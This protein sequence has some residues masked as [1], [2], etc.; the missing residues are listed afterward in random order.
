M[1]ESIFWGKTMATVRIT[2]LTIKTII[3]TNTWERTTKQKVVI[4]TVFDYDAR[5]AA[6]TDRIQ[7][8]VD[9]KTI[10]KEII[11]CVR[12]SKFFLLEKL[13]DCVLKIIMKNKMV[14]TAHVRIDKPKAL[15]FAKSVSVELFAKR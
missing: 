1:E 7:D 8:T 13:T 4:N 5:R 11:A 12:A 15:R 6:R 10:T 3:G 2:D 14:K 9:Y